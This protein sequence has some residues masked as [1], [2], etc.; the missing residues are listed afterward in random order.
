MKHLLASVVLGVGLV[1]SSAHAADKSDG[2]DTRPGAGNKGVFLTGKVG[3][4]VPFGGLSPF[5]T[6]GIDVGYALDNGL[7]FGV[8]GDYTAPHKSGTEQ[9][10]RITPSGSYTWHL[11]EQQL[12]LMPFVMYRLK[13]KSIVP[14]A[15]IGPRFYFLRS[16]VRSGDG[17]P[18]F[19]ET[20]ERSG[21]IGFGVPLGIEL[22]LGPG[23]G[24]AEVL[25]QYGGLDH[26]ATGNSNT[27]AASLA[28]G[29][30]VMF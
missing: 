14:Y 8:A 24:I 3:G 13:L 17:G 28:L 15:G 7:A 30:R 27:G 1:A 9:D 22:A 5:V 4:I 6:A 21:K 29:Y 18:S 12:Q 26:T 25:L 11:T 19:Q 16:T 23:A 2:S 20:T 10:T